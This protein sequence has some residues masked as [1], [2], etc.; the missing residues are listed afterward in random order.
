MEYLTN[1]EEYK[2][3]HP[4]LQ[5]HLYFLSRKEKW[6]GEYQIQL[7][8]FKDELEK[9]TNRKLPINIQI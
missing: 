9:Q 3:L 6:Q 7:L 2:K 5:F 4:Y 1:S 8:G